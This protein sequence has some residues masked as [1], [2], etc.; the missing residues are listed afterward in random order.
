MRT[1]R[2]KFLQWSAAVA[3]PLVVA[4]R[5]LGLEG[6]VNAASERITVGCIGIGCMGRG[7]LGLILERPDAQVLAVSDVDDW[8]LDYGKTRVDTKY[9]NTDCMATIEFRDVLD[10]RDIDAVTVILGERWHPFAVSMAAHAGKDIYVEKPVA[11]TIE[12]ATRMTE[13]VRRAGVICQVGLQQR[14]D[15]EFI[16]AVKIIH[17]G[18]LGKIRRIYVIHNDA[19]QDVD[20]PAEPTPPTIHWDRW[21]GPSPW[22]P[23]NSRFHYLGE[24]KNVVPWSFHKDFGNGGL[25][26]GCVHAFDIVQWALGMDHTGPVYIAAPESGKVP[27]VTY[28]YDNYPG[29]TGTIVQVTNGTIDPNVCDVPKGWNPATPIEPFGGV[30]VGDHGW[31]H[32]GRQGV[33]TSFPEEITRD[34][35]VGPGQGVKEHHDD[36]FDAMRSRRRPHADIAIGAHS[37]HLSNLGCIARWTGRELFWDPT[38]EEF[39]NDE[40]ANRMRRRAW[41]NEWYI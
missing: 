11:L 9:G 5:A 18:V 2:R 12:Q 25:G 3:A 26:S 17:S 27:F 20:L 10:R 31:L 28:R 37:T 23:W 22:H 19:S 35:Q 40:N 1:N 14:S 21:V 24:P 33:L 15:L 8:R 29:E 34:F 38:K 30:Y 13:A 32:V 41:R 4:G 39:K 36:W 6:G 16:N 7:H